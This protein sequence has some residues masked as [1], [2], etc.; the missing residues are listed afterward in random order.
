MSIAAEMVEAE[1]RRVFPAHCLEG[2]GPLSTGD[3]EENIRIRA[4]L[5]AI[6]DWTTLVPDM[7]ADIDR[8]SGFGFLTKE[9]AQFY[10]PAFLV[11]DLRGADLNSDPVSHLCVFD[12]ST[13]TDE[14]IAWQLTLLREHWDVLDL[15][16]AAAVC[17]YLEWRIA[18]RTRGNERE[19]SFSLAA[20][21]Y[22]RT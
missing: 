15:G 20:Y 18:T 21:W 14:V 10:L 12:L 5:A 16:Q 3:R 4:D 22:Q 9:A 2:F 6:T 19:V 8:H 1:I 11:A 17:S 13:S 7:M